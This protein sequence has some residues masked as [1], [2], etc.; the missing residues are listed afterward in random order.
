MGTLSTV[1]NLDFVEGVL[2]SEHPLFEVGTK[3]R[4]YFNCFE[5]I[6]AAGYPVI[7]GANAISHLMAQEGLSNYFNRIGEGIRL[8][9]IRTSEVVPVSSDRFRFESVPGFLEYLSRF[10]QV[11]MS[12]Y[13]DSPVTGGRTGIFLIK[14][15]QLALIGLLNF[16]KSEKQLEY[17]G[18]VPVHSKVNSNTYQ[19]APSPKIDGVDFNF[20]R[21]FA[22]RNSDGN[23]NRL[24]GFAE[25]GINFP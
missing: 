4:A 6:M 12:R 10:G 14:D 2:S 11:G 7:N 24:D 21:L 16:N 1:K 23:W 20:V 22:Q 8:Q 13:L 17:C 5:D 15:M 19:L 9:G 25:R 3:I 18:H